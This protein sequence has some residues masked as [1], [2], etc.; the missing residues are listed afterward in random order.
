MVQSTQKVS[1]PPE[2]APRPLSRLTVAYMIQLCEHMFRPLGP[3][4]QPRF[5]ISKLPTTLFAMGFDRDFVSTCDFQYYWNFAVLFPALHDGSFYQHA[6]YAQARGQDLLRG[7]ATFLCG[8]FVQNPWLGTRL[9]DSFE[10]SLFS[11]GYQFVAGKLVETGV[12]TSTS[13]E[14]AAMPNK[15]SL[16]QDLSLQ[17]QSNEFVAVLFVDLDHFKQVNDRLG[18][19]EGDRCLSAVVQAM[20]RVMQHKGK[21]YRVGGDEFCVMLPNFS[22]PEA[23]AAAERLRASIDALAP[24]GGVVKVTASIGVAVS[25][26][27]GLATPATLVKAADDAMYV[28]KFTTKNRICLWPPDAA[29][30]AQA[31]INRRDAAKAGKR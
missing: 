31:D 28:S 18:H 30:A 14:L 9:K 23:V 25:D 27:K 8:T 22:T 15:D 6:I 5:D 7:F 26:G 17:L 24:F 12:D 29:E 11:D 1:T 2:A 19:P 20:S 21:L 4:R 16:L 13:P 3:L 10:Q